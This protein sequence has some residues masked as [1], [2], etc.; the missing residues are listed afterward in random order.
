MRNDFTSTLY[1]QIR[2]DC[3]NYYFDSSVNGVV[4]VQEYSEAVGSYIT[5]TKVG[6]GGIQV[7]GATS[8]L[9]LSVNNWQFFPDATLN[10]P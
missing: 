7:Q 9:Y 2:D 1:L 3:T 8:P 4:W 10:G 6:F 5:A